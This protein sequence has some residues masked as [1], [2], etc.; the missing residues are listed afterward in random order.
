MGRRCVIPG[1]KCNYDASK[2]ASCKLKERNDSG[3]I[4]LV[5]NPVF[6]FTSETKFTGE[7]RKW[8]KAIP[9]RDEN[10]INICKTLSVAYAKHWPDGFEKKNL[11][12]E[13]RPKHPPSMFNNL[14]QSCVPRPPPL[15]RTTTRSTF[16]VRTT[17]E[18]KL[19]SFSTADKFTYEAVKQNI[20]FHDFH[21]TKI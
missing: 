14:P 16:D 9:L 21:A 8:I 18:S 5:K 15:S 1:C 4:V 20:S 3:N 2:A 12:G 10:T 13:E 19:P 11:R 6:G 7:R 17:I